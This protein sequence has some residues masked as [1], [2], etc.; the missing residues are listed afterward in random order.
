MCM[1]VHKAAQPL[2]HRLWLLVA[3]SRV[4]LMPP[5]YLNVVCELTSCRSLVA[6]TVA[7]LSWVTRL[8]TL[9]QH[10]LLQITPFY[11]VALQLVQ[12]L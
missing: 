3:G 9:W 8:A 7:T 10:L 12:P 4:L 6:A 5:W 2:A 1:L 11:K